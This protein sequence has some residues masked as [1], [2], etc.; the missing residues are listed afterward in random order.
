MRLASIVITPL[1]IFL[2]LQLGG[3]TNTRS[4]SITPPPPGGAYVS[5]SAGAFFDQS[6]TLETPQVSGENATTIAQFP[7]Q[8]AF[9]PDFA[10]DTIYIAAGSQGY[11]VSNNNGT[12]WHQVTVPLAAA[13]D[14]VVLPQNVIVVTGVDAQGQ[15][16]IIRSADEGRS[17]QVVLTVPVPVEKRGLQLVK[18]PGGG[19]AAATVII[20]I[21]SDPFQPDQLYAGTSLGNIFKG[22]QYA[23]T[24]HLTHTL[25]K[26]ALSIGSNTSYIIK[27]IIPSPFQAGQLLILTSDQK[28]FQLDGNDKISE[29]AVKLKSESASLFASSVSKKVLDAAYITGFPDAL[30][31]GVE[32][33]A[34]ISR[35]RGATWQQLPLPVD[36]IKSFNTVIVTTSPRN[37][38]RLL[39][40]IN[41]VVYR[42][43]DG[44]RTW[45][46]F[47]LGLPNYTIYSLL[48]NPD[49]PSH[50]LA[51][52]SPL[53]S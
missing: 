35:D 24:W 40:A 42:S 7:L 28:L 8:S 1:V 34:V 50:V 52:T 5:K 46:V 15:G 13:Y 25:G 27:Q 2:A 36:T 9:R 16:Y 22:E 41:D 44:G 30:L 12:S 21:A 49:N 6:V 38:S 3:C 18:P 17:W 39:V 51:L 11:I 32:D 14:I 47:T 37:P 4:K 29:L 20:S 45:N 31:V 43:E 19:E 48:I 53:T 33:G 23:K 10:P 26:G